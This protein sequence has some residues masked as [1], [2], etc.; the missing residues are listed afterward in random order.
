MTKLTEAQIATLQRGAQ[1][2]NGLIS[3]AP[4]TPVAMAIQAAKKLEVTGL[5]E[6]VPCFHDEPW[7]FRDEDT[8][9]GQGYRLTAAGFEALGIDPSEWPAYCQRDPEAPVDPQ[10]AE[11]DAQ[12]TA[13]AQTRLD[14]L[15]AGGQILTGAAL[16]A[17]I[18]E[19]EG[20]AAASDTTDQPAAAFDDAG[21]L[22]AAG[23]APAADQPLVTATELAA[24]MTAAEA[25]AATDAFLARSAA[26]PL[27]GNTLQRMVQASDAFLAV[28]DAEV[29]AGK[30]F[31][32]AL[33]EAVEQLRLAP[34]RA[35]SAPKA[36]GEPG[37]PK[38]GSKLAQ[39]IA[40]LSRK[41]GALAAEVEQATGWNNTST[42][43]FIS[44]LRIKRGLAVATRKEAGT[45]RYWI[46]EDNAPEAL[47]AAEKPAKAAKAEGEP[48]F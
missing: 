20:Q 3:P 18:D 5:V 42:R 33:A 23:L 9:E 35:V 11:Q 32:P 34:Q 29:A 38:P 12:D 1:H 48:A 41:G 22:D 24:S 19:W 26:S 47:P 45:T 31:S 16:Q 44:S 8:G 21:F 36:A 14:E 10:E 46:G 4:K 30:G 43:G 7:Y 25:N 17:R 13:L 37:V 28:W 2:A 6:L 39:V 15:Q 27:R 40:L